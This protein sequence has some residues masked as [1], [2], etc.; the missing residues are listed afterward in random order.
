MYT[1]TILEELYLPSVIIGIC[2]DNQ[3]LETYP[4]SFNFPAI[5]AQAICSPVDKITSFSELENSLAIF[6]VFDSNSFVTPL[7]AEVIT[8]TL[9]FLLT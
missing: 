9:Y 2:H 8:I 4:K 5:N 7:I 6:L 3:D 1:L